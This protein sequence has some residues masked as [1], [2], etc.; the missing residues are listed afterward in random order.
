MSA[1]ERLAPSF[2]W[3]KH[4]SGCWGAVPSHIPPKTPGKAEGGTGSGPSGKALEAAA[5]AGRFG[6]SCSA[7]GAGRSRCPSARHT[8]LP[9]PCPA[10]RARAREGAA[11]LQLDGQVPSCLLGFAKPR[12]APPLPLSAAWAWLSCSPGSSSSWFSPPSW[13]GATSRRWFAGIGS[14]RRFIRW[15]ATH[16]HALPC[17][18][19]LPC[20]KTPP[21][22]LCP[23]PKPD[24]KS[25]ILD[26]KIKFRISTS[27]LHQQLGIA[28]VLLIHLLIALPWSSGIPGVLGAGSSVWW[29]RER[30]WGGGT[31][32]RTLPVAVS[33]TGWSQHGAVPPNTPHTLQRGVSK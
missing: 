30:D 11:G 13:L 21:R 2:S 1:E 16:I 8:R 14:T 26:Q 6:R 12:P 23:A 18:S 9:G 27:D 29:A 28:L 19:L 17:K 4:L 24:R 5:F 20:T 31:G 22:A 32:V 7:L 3:C 33:H 10:R 25:P 15:V